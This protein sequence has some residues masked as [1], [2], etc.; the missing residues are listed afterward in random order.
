MFEQTGTIP[1]CR[2]HARHEGFGNESRRDCTAQAKQVRY[3]R[4]DTFGCFVSVASVARAL[5][6]TLFAFSRG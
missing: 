5:T 4:H 6:R 1:A 3:K 2:H